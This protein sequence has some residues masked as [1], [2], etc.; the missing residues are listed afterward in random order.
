LER[1][2]GGL[3]GRRSGA[4]FQHREERLVA[5]LVSSLAAA[6]SSLTAP[7]RALRA[8]AWESE[9]RGRECNE[10]GVDA[11]SALSANHTASRRAGFARAES[12]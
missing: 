6:A 7:A 9:V 8:T 12:K 2:K 11:K 1:R 5:G 4:A 10:L 3:A